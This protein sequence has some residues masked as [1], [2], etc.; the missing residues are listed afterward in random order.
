[1]HTINIHEAK[2]KL[3]RL[4]EEVQDGSDVVIAKAGWPIARLTAY[5]PPRPRIAAPGKMQGEG[6]MAD[7]FVAPLD[8]LF[9]AF[10]LHAPEEPR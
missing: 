8:T 2:T 4:L 3:S 9:H 1:M 7:D 10:S 6:W 5:A